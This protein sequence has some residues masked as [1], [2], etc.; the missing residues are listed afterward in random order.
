MNGVDRGA[1][2]MDPAVEEQREL[3]TTSYPSGLRSHHAHGRILVGVDGS[4]GS[5]CALR[6]AARQAEL[7]GASLEVVMAWEIPVVPYGVWMAY[8]A[9][10]E[11]QEAL[12]TAV[13]EVLG[14][15]DQSHV[16][17]TA[18]EGRPEFALLEAAKKADL[19]VVGTRGHG[20][21]ASLLLGSVS[22]HCAT[23][24]SCPVV[25]V[26]RCR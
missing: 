7:T 26:P 23:H 4:E 22:Q 21:F 9:G 2:L 10:A 12:G 16:V 25:I 15:S 5:K 19:L 3:S 24:A 11:A 18:T 8:D 17:A 20:S 1:S 6:W 13:Q 14:R